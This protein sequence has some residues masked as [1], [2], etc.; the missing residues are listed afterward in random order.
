MI[1][2]F[3]ETTVRIPRAA[4]TRIYNDLLKKT[5]ALNVICV[6]DAFSKKINM[7]YR[8]KNVPANILTFPP[9]DDT[10]AEI[11]INTTMAAKTAKKCGISTKKQ[12]LRLYIHGIAHLLGYTHGKEMETTEN[13]YATKYI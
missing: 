12:I 13:R 6:G 1:H 8:K 2:I 9:N 5:C 3:N 10:I 4:M 11:Y 7:R